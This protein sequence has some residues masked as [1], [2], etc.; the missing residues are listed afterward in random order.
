MVR[1][2]YRSTSSAH[3]RKPNFSLRV[4]WCRSV[5][6]PWS[7]RVCSTNEA[8]SRHGTDVGLIREVRNGSRIS[9]ATLEKFEAHIGHMVVAKTGARS[10]RGGEQRRVEQCVLPWTYLASFSPRPAKISVIRHWTRHERRG[11]RTQ[12]LVV[13]PLVFQSQTTI[14]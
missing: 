12:E 5:N 4:R 14:I 9:G 13:R 1:E 3:T 8:K 10:E 2:G 7:W 11:H 6:R